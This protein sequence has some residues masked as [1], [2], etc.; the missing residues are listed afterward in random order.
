MRTVLQVVARRVGLERTCLDFKQ[1]TNEQLV[2]LFLPK[3]LIKLDTFNFAQV[4]DAGWRKAVNFSSDAGNI[5]I[6]FILSGSSMTDTGIVPGSLIINADFCNDIDGKY[7]DKRFDAVHLDNASYRSLN[8]LLTK[9]GIKQQVL[10][11][12][13]KMFNVH[14]TG[15]TLKQCVDEINDRIMQDNGT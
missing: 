1:R 8:E 2:E 14:N 10:V 12:V 3:E 9:S 5:R 6:K 4:N 11:Y 13:K 7:L 15:K